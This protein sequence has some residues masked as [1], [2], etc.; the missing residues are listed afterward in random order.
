MQL[1]AKDYKFKV[2]ANHA[3]DESYGDNGSDMVMTVENAGLYNVTFTFFSEA[4]T[5]TAELGTASGIKNVKMGST[6]ATVI[7]NLQGQRVKDG[8]RG[9]AIKNGHKVVIK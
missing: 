4:K 7:Y 3:W 9:I 6:N 8:Y 5:L 1:E 2:C